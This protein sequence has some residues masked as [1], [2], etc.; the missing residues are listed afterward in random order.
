[1]A[2]NFSHKRQ[3]KQKGGAQNP[4][5][6]E[7]NKVVKQLDIEYNLLILKQNLMVIPVI[8]KYQQNLLVL[9]MHS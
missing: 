4:S 1:M 3:S 2:M 9:H 6:A 7:S 8:L 5:N